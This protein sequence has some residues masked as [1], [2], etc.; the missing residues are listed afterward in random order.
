MPTIEELIEERIKNPPTTAGTNYGPQAKHS[1][2]KLFMEDLLKT[3]LFM[4]TL[5]TEAELEGNETLAAI[6]SLIYDGTPEEVA[7]NFKNQGNEAYQAGPREF[8]HAISYYTKGLEQKVDSPKLNATLHCNRA[9]VNLELGEVSQGAFLDWAS[10]EGLTLNSTGNYRRVLNDCA[11]AI[12]LQ[13]DNLK[14]YYRS[15]KALVALDKLDEA[16]DCCELALQIDPR[17]AAIMTE[18]SKAVKKKA[19]LDETRQSRMEREARKAEEE[20]RLQEAIKSRGINM[21]TSRPTRRSN[22]NDDSEDETISLPPTSSFVHP[23]Q[24]DHRPTFDSTTDTLSFPVV[25]LYPEHS[26]SD[27]IA[28]FRE[29]DTFQDH[30]DLM[31]GDQRPA[32]DADETYDPTNLEVYFE[33]H[34]HRPKDHD[35]PVRL[36]RAGCGLQ[37][38]T[39][40]TQPGFRVVDGVCTFFVVPKASTFGK[41]FRKRYRQP[42]VA[43]KA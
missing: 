18:Q 21:T 6:H 16:L 10:P 27:L 33:S 39:V 40:L 38:K 8:K 13:P 5:P 29:D 36:L 30:L 14:A 20:R 42:A 23:S 4:K 32:W 12:T 2:P 24:G 28:L 7:V 15:I 19:L 3:P 37:L 31:F 11:A 25:F 1:D 34:D 17:N 41:S 22:N 35:G 43:T 9:A 26:Q